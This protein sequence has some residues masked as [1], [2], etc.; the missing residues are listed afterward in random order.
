MAAG[1][2]AAA[3]KDHTELVLKIATALA[4]S[5]HGEAVARMTGMA[6][7][8][9]ADAPLWAVHKGYRGP[10]GRTALQYAA[11]AGDAARVRFLVELGPGEATALMLASERGHLD[12]VRCL[13]EQG[14]AT[15][16][17]A[18][19]ALNLAAQ[20]GHYRVVSYLAGHACAGA[21]EALA[22]AACAQGRLGLVRCLAEWGGV[23][24]MSADGSTALMVASEKGFLE[25]VHFLVE[26]GGA[27]VDSA[28]ASDGRTALLWACEKGHLDIVRCLVEQGGADVNLARADGSTALMDA[29]EKGCLGIVRCLVEQGGADVDSA[30]ASDGQTA[31]LWACEK[32]HLDIVRCLVERG[33]AAVNPARRSDGQTALL[34]ACENGHLDIARCLVQGGVDVNLARAADGRTP[35]M[36][37]AACGHLLS[38]ESYPTV[39]VALVCL[40]LQH[41][42]DMRSLDVAGR[43]AFDFAKSFPFASHV[44]GLLE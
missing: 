31:L 22:L 43:K 26:H 9:R 28:R 27:A 36:C 13:V 29:S 23:D 4:L 33:G 7:A 25:I 21:C 34:W 41:G 44:R 5:G 8:F 2:R 1:T 39:S 14:G 35:L 30:R 11:W 37:A 16:D 17:A 15:M 20:N 6:R 3:A 18:G 38:G 42:A 24:V 10:R 32:G 12:A 19:V 40:L